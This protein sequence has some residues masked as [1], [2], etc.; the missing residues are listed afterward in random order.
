MND[1][2]ACRAGG[3]VKR[4]CT[5]VPPS[6]TVIVFANLPL[7]TGTSYIYRFRSFF[8]LN[9]FEFQ[10]QLFPYCRG[11]ESSMRRQEKRWNDLVLSWQPHFYASF[12]LLF[13]TEKSIV[14]DVFIF[15]PLFANRRSGDRIPVGTRFSAPVQT[16]PG[17]HPASCTMGTGSVPGV[18]SGRGVTLTPHPLLV[19]L[20]AV[21]PVQSLSACT[22]VHF[23]FFFFIC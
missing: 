21:G 4:T 22:K 17:A 10:L 7:L 5:V 18:K 11:L 12:G 6:Q 9:V 13:Q 1:L 23:T 20:W 3:F 14:E 19:P 16:G 2:L 8:A 15:N